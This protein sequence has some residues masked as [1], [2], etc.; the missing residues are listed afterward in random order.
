MPW[1]WSRKPEVRQGSYTD[2]AISLLVQAAGGA[3]SGDANSTGALEA[4]AGM[5]SRCFAAATVDPDIEVLTPTM[6]ATAARAL[7]RRGEI[8]FQIDVMNGRLVLHPIG[9]FDV[10]G[11]ADPASWAYRCVRHGPSR[12]ETTLLTADQVLHFRYATEPSRPWKGV[13]PLG[14]AHRLGDLIGNAET[15]LSQEASGT[16]GRVLPMPTDGGDGGDNDPLALLKTDLAKGGGRLHFVETTSAGFGE[17]HV[18]A[19]SQDWM[20]KRIGP[21]PD[22]EFVKL[23]EQAQMAVSCGL[24]DSTGIIVFGQRRHPWRERVLSSVPPFR[25]AP[26]GAHDEPMRSRAED[27]HQASR[28]TS[29]RCTLPTSPAAPVPSN[30][31]L[32]GGM[33]V[34]EALALSGL[35]VAED[36]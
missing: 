14:L 31:S 25:R 23:R 5:W 24:R 28:S 1:P 17:G 9:D 26:G 3:V 34:A 12:T 33:A 8:V 10:R 18:A 29:R 32:A 2:A 4:A 22:G 13:G 6:M 15:R 36:A 20:Q 35:M 19:P 16:V 11:A 30:V 27:R 7:I 21:M